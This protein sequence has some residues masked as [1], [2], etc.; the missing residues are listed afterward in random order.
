[1]ALSPSRRCRGR[2][3]AAM[4]CSV[5]VGAAAEGPMPGDAINASIRHVCAGCKRLAAGAGAIPR[6]PTRMAA[7]GHRRGVDRH[8]IPCATGHGLRDVGGAARGRG[9]LGGR[10]STCPLRRA[11]HVE[12]AVGRPR[13]DHRI[14]DRCRARSRRVGRRFALCRAGGCPCRPGRC[15]VPSRSAGA[16]GLPGQLVVAARADRVHDRHRDLDDG[17]PARQG[18]RC[19]GLR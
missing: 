9:P 11:W 1:M 12:E 16:V 10:P 3:K 7:R 18:H 17:Q 5:A 4:V 2:D 8:G 19:T 13:I 14:D 15:G 6:L